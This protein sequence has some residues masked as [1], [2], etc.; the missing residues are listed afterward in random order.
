MVPYIHEGLL[1][2]AQFWGI[3]TPGLPTPLN[4]QMEVSTLV[5]THIYHM[6]TIIMLALNLGKTSILP[7]QRTMIVE[8]LP[9]IVWERCT[10]GNRIVLLQGL[11]PPS[12]HD[13]ACAAVLSPAPPPPPPPPPPASIVNHWHFVR[14][15]G[16]V[17]GG[18]G[19]AVALPAGL[20]KGAPK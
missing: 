5:D 13:C 12:F 8:D 18:A 1:A 10:L 14:I 2:H 17:A 3:E 16:E 9:C 11:I 15:S 4:A 19:G 7:S 6:G 20:K